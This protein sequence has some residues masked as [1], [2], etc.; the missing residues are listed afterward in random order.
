M[1]YRILPGILP[2]LFI[3]LLLIS[4]LGCTPDVREVVGS[5]PA[6]AL[7]ALW[8]RGNYQALFMELH[9]DDSE[10]LQEYD[11]SEL[12]LYGFSAYRLYEHS[13]DPA[14]LESAVAVLERVLY[15]YQ[16][17]VSE[18]QLE[19][20]IRLLARVGYLSGDY[21]Q[22]ISLIEEYG[23]LATDFSSEMLMLKL[24]AE[25][26]SGNYAAAS[27]LLDDFPNES[28]EIPSAE[29]T[30][31]ERLTL[32]LLAAAVLL[33]APNAPDSTAAEEQLTELLQLPGT[34]ELFRFYAGMLAVNS[35]LARGD[36]DEAG[37][38]LEMLR[39]RIS[40]SLLLSSIYYTLGV[41]NRNAGEMIEARTMWNRALEYNPQNSFAAGKL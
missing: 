2:I 3:I 37:R 7:I 14:L 6:D 33:T 29:L 21:Q 24:F 1:K 27:L 9:V 38:L 12:L 13:G 15:L 11:S 20:L 17:D 8:E 4:V 32:D 30:E 10:S 23:A 26:R 22:T 35:L 36:Y 39:G 5:S 31:N 28:E 34:G 25:I 18:A 16:D 19:E 40:S 41:V